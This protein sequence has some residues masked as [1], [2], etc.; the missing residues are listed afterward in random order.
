M[1]EILFYDFLDEHASRIKTKGWQFVN[2]D[3][4]PD[5][6]LICHVTSDR[7]VKISLFDHDVDEYSHFNVGNSPLLGE[8]AKEYFHF[9]LQFFVR[10]DNDDGLQSS[11]N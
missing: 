10:Q 11:A 2:K 7:H 6:T 3:V 8:E 5:F 4:F 9:P 1:F